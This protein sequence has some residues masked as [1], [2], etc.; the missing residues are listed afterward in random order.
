MRRAGIPE[1]CVITPRRRLA[2]RLFFRPRAFGGRQPLT[3]SL[4]P[5]FAAPST[6]PPHTSRSLRLNDLQKRCTVDNFRQ[7]MFHGRTDL[8]RKQ[9]VAEWDGSWEERRWRNSS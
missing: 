9:V 2:K 1:W 7:T 8:G 5:P 4:R 3:N 6:S